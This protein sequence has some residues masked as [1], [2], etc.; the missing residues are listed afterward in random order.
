MIRLCEAR[1]QLK[2][3]LR[4]ARSAADADKRPVSF[5]AMKADKAELG[6][7]LMARRRRKDRPSR[8]GGRARKPPA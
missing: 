5:T 1:M 8:L 6:V 3:S 7:K 2:L 4:L